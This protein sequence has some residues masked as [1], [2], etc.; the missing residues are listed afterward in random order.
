MKKYWHA[1]GAIIPE[2]MGDLS[3]AW[4]SVVI[5]PTKSPGVASVWRMH[6]YMDLPYLCTWDY[7]PTTQE[8]NAL[9][10][11]DE[12]FDPFRVEITQHERHQL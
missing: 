1:Y 10:P 12:G 8:R 4:M 11:S 2:N 9:E 3:G 7:E 5:G 6:G